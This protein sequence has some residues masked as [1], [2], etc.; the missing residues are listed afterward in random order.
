MSQSRSGIELVGEW[1]ECSGNQSQGVLV[2]E[3]DW[4]DS[5]QKSS[6]KF[7][8]LREAWESHNERVISKALKDFEDAENEREIAE[9]NA[10]FYPAFPPKTDQ[11]REKYGLTV[12]EVDEVVIKMSRR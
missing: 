9:V 12:K 4:Q 2:E 8:A 3:K 10:G 1:W 5:I 6:E 11:G 7:Q